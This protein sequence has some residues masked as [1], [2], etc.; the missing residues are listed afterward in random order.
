M[1]HNDVTMIK[2][3]IYFSTYERKLWMK[4]HSESGHDL[5]TQK[6]IHF[7]LRI[8]IIYNQDSISFFLKI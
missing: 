7:N 3:E 8:C 5:E 6:N 2:L 4:R 1:K